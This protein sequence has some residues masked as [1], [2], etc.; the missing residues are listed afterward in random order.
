VDQV[1][2]PD[3]LYAQGVGQGVAKFTWK[4]EVPNICNESEHSD[5]RAKFVLRSDNPLPAG[6]DAYGEVYTPAGHDP[7]DVDLEEGSAFDSIFTATRSNIGVAQYPSPVR[8]IFYLNLQFPFSGSLD[9]ARKQL[10]A[11][12]LDFVSIEVFYLPFQK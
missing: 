11:A 5:T 6:A 3:N 12:S 7:P 2:R 4:L 9:E 1:L 10:E 8:L